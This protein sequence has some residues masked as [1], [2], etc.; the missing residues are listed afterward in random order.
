MGGE[1]VM[2]AASI[3]GAAL[4]LKHRPTRAGAWYTLAAW[5]HANGDAAAERAR[6]RAEYMK[7]AKAKCHA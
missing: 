3:A 5:A 7:E 4:Y 6:R 2:L 1:V